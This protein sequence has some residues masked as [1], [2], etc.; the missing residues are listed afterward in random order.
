MR[1]TRCAPITTTHLMK[2]DEGLDPERH[3]TSP[4]GPGVASALLSFTVSVVGKPK[5]DVT[6]RP[7]VTQTD[8]S[9]EVSQSLTLF[10]S[11]LL[12]ISISV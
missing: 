2:S 12:L 9:L 3:G 6:R 11:S 7:C 4:R 5:S 10:Q 8:L 1:S